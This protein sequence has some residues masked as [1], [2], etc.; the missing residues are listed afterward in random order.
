MLIRTTTYIQRFIKNLTF[1]VNQ[2]KLNQHEP[3]QN[4]RVK[5][6]STTEDL[7]KAKILWYKFAQ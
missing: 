5:Y 4:Q 1:Y 7:H 3:L 2:R 6:F